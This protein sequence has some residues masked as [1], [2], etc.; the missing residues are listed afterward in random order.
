MQV[1]LAQVAEFEREYPGPNEAPPPD[2]APPH[3]AIPE[4]VDGDPDY[5]PD[6]EPVNT[7]GTAQA[8][9]AADKLAGEIL[10][11]E[12]FDASQWEGVPIPPRRWIA[13]NRIP[14]GEPGIMSGDGGTGKTK[15]ALQ[16]GVSIAAGL[17]DWIGG[18]VDAEGPVIVY[19]AEEKLTE[20]HR[21]IVDILESRGLS[22]GD[23][24]SRLRFIC[25]YDDPVLGACG[26][27]NGVVQPTMSLCRLEKTVQAVR[28]A[29][30]IV[31]N[32]A[33][34]YNGSEIDRTN[35]TRFM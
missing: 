11:L 26:G 1:T 22:F 21:R 34:V 20:M 17:R 31:E 14:Q 33:D 9:T 25:D 32:A 35:V 6:A 5:G 28:P 2:P 29:M 8:P 10:P 30:V 4:G 24:Q 12:T 13:F 18:V 19:S 15:L 23:L 27:R 7:G 3:D 16:L